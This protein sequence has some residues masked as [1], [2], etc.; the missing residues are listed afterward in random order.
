VLSFMAERAIKA[1][2]ELVRSADR[3]R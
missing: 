2:E 1:D 3:L